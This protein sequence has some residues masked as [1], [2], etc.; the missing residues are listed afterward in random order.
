MRCA[1]N[2]EYVIG[3]LLGIFTI[4]FILL[5]FLGLC[6]LRVPPICYLISGSV[7]LILFGLGLFFRKRGLAKLEAANMMICPFCQY[8]V[9]NLRVTAKDGHWRCPECGCM[10]NKELVT[11]LWTEA[12]KEP[13]SEIG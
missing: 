8:D 1:T 3:W 12:Y 13:T 10:M 6:G 9:H 5:V 4:C 11:Q 2:I 7:T